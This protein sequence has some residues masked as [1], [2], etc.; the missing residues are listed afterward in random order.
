[1]PTQKEYRRKIASFGHTELKRLW[2][3]I[4]RGRTPGWGAGKALEYLILRAFE[5][6]AAEVAWPYYVRVA[7]SALEEIDGVIYCEG[8]VALIECKDYSKPVNFE[9]V[10]KLRQKLARR[11]PLVLGCC[12]A[13]KGFTEEA[14]L[15]AERSSPQNV[16]LW[17]GED[18]E[19]AIEESRM[20]ETLRAKFRHAVEH[21]L[22][23]FSIHLS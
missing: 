10:A 9:A 16:L 21:A 2:K 1:M 22:P 14:T 5:L 20:V 18:V 13:R 12:I 6:E 23:D 15:L 11:P 4:S 17:R 8:L 3:D 7:G 19:F